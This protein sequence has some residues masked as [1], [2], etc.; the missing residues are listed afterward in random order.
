MPE[1]KKDSFTFS[2]KI[3]NNKPAAGNKSF[4]KS[5]SKVGR[6][7]KPKQTLFERTRRDAPFFIAALVALLLLP[8]L[9]KFS[10]QASEEP[11]VS[12]ANEDT[13]FDPDHYG[14]DTA[15]LEDPDGQIAQLSGRDALDLI[16]GFGGDQEEDYGRDDLDLDASADYSSQAEGEYAAEK[17][18]SSEMDVE[19]NTTNIYKRRAGRNTRRAF[20]RTKV[21]TLNSSQL[22]RSSGG[23][24]GVPNYGGGLKEAAKKVK[25]GTPVAPPKPVSLQP[26]R[27]AGPARSSFGQGAGQAARRSKDNMGKA[28]AVEALRDS[29]VK[30]VDPTRF[31]GLDLFGGGP[32]GGNGGLNRNINVGKGETPWWWDMMKN[33]M[34]QEWQAQFDRKWKWI[35]WFDEWAWN[36]LKGL[37]NCIVTGNEDGDP[38]TFLGH[39]GDEAGSI[40]KTECC[41]INE[42]EWKVSAGLGMKGIPFTK[43]ACKNNVKEVLAAVGKKDVKDCGSDMWVDT[44]AAGGGNRGFIGQRLCCLGFCPGAKFKGEAKASFGEASNCD[45]MPGLYQVNAADLP[46]KWQKHT[47]IYV[48]ARNYLP[49]TFRIKMDPKAPRGFLCVDGRDHNKGTADPFDFGKHSSGGAVSAMDAQYEIGDDEASD[50]YVEQLSVSTPNATTDQTRYA[51]TYMSDPESIQYGCVIDVVNSAYWDY[52]TF[53]D[54]MLGILKQ[55]A[56]KQN[57]PDPYDDGYHTVANEAFA[58]LDLMFVGS[59]A[60]KNKLAY[61]KWFESGNE[62]NDILPMVY[63]RFKGAY[64]DHKKSTHKQTGSRVK[65]KNR[66]YRR[67]GVDVGFGQQ[68]YFDQS[69]SIACEPNAEKPYATVT[70]KS[71]YKGGQGFATYQGVT[72]Q[73]S[74]PTVTQP[75]GKVNRYTVNAMSE[76]KNIVVEAQ[77]FP[78]N[79]E[80]GKGAVQRLDHP[81]VV[82]GSQ[83][84]LRYTFDPANMRDSKGDKMGGEG[85]ELVG[86]VRFTLK[87]AGK[88]IQTVS[89]PFNLSG[90]GPSIIVDP[91]PCPK[92]AQTSQKC[93]EEIYAAQDPANEYKWEGGKCVITPKNKCPQGKDTNKECCEEADRMDSSDTVYTWNDQTKKCDTSKPVPPGPKPYTVFAPQISC[94]PNGI[95]DRKPVTQDISCS[96]FGTPLVKKYTTS[97]QSCHDLFGFPMDSQK[98]TDFVNEVKEAYNKKFTDKPAIKFDKKYPL[99]SEF[100]DALNIAQSVGITKVSKAAVCEM[101]RDFVRMSKDKHVGS[102]SIVEGATGTKEEALIFRNELG[103]YLAYVHDTSILYPDAFVRV[104]GQNHCDW[105]FQPYGLADGGCPRN[106]GPKMGKGYA[107]NNYNGTKFAD[108]YSKYF[109]PSLTDIMKQ[110]PLKA[111]VS[112]RADLPHNCGN[113]KSMNG[114]NYVKQYNSY[115]GFAG[116]LHEE[117]ESINGQGVAC[118]AFLGGGDAKMDVADAL[119]Y[120]Q[121]LCTAGLDY[122]PVGQ[123]KKE[124]V[125]GQGPTSSGG[126]SGAD[127]ITGRRI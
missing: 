96:L 81:E 94:V 82:P 103:A 12:T 101:G 26:L 112:G 60:A 49:D 33:R 13:A 80:K 1:E 23:R 91:K 58:Q 4:A 104:K 14:F 83:N 64:L 102:R 113:C 28:N 122:K 6:D 88:E 125:E 120:I 3:K 61:A 41:G 124:Y 72:V 8:F 117:N 85:V 53:A 43:K 79:S 38:N 106:G 65:I 54:R 87:R 30:P 25:S 35:K 100:I 18:A 107:H 69:L 29:Y 109:V 20:R 84:Q 119:K 50:Q 89:C 111:L 42:E 21:G 70:F 75:F 5:S 67:V 22:P 123:G 118:E 10:G 68:C 93:C 66:K 19:E 27:A 98:A 37:A 15:M 17:H 127:Q 57:L 62:L 36:I 77:M 63:W 24:L 71:N 121:G 52:N 55:L 40:G 11:L 31:G 48:V 108:K 74:S 76:R 16:K 73:G 45:A 39:I 47:Y 105:R 86:N 59:M 92:G 95:H 99:D 2:D 114:K 7:G 9:Y 46:R 110:A 51:S 126:T 115:S 116:L 78:L 44:K 97:G 90:D 34:Q 56:K 32:G